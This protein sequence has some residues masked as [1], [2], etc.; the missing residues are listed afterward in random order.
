MMQMRSTFLWDF[1]QR[2]RRIL[3]VGLLDSWTWYR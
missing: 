3:L 2:R 1:M